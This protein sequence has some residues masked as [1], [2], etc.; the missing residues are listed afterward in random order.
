[1]STPVTKDD[2]L[3][4]TGASGIL[5]SH[6]GPVLRTEFPDT[7]LLSVRRKDYDL[8]LQADVERTFRDL[9][10][11]SVIH[12]AANVGGIL[13]NRDLPADF[14]Y[15]NLLNNTLVVEHARR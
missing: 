14:C 10:P 2:R 13:A 12:L 1:M 11:T 4:V 8:L 3:L 6:I 15:E 9:Q 5:R 7:L